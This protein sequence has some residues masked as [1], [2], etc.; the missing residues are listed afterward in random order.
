[1]VGY[2]SLGMAATKNAMRQEKLSCP[3][4]VCPLYDTTLF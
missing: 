4:K 1:M 2:Y 3:K